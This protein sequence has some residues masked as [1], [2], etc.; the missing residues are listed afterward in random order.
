M[1]ENILNTEEPK[2]SLN[3]IIKIMSNC[4]VIKTIIN[5]EPGEPSVP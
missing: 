1:S 2:K 4:Q 5:T 3:F